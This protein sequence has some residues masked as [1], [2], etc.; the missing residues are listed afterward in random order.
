MLSPISTVLDC[1][2]TFVAV[3][4]T[5]K[6]PETYKFPVM[7]VLPTTDTRPVPLGRNSK[8]EFETVNAYYDNPLPGVVY[9]QKHLR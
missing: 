2:L 4:K 8:F 6:L 1:K 3:P 7:F 9:M 5:S